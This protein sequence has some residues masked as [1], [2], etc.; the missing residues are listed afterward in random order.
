MN[1]INKWTH[2]WL[3]YDINNKS[4]KRHIDIINGCVIDLGC[5][6]SPYRDDI[7]KHATYYIG[8]DWINS[9]HNLRHV[10]IFANIS[11]YLPIK[12][13]SI[14]TIVSFQVLE[15]LQN[16]IFFLAECFRILR[17]GGRLLITTPFNW[18]VHE[19]PYDYYRF[20]RFG[21][22]YLLNLNSYQKISVEENT[23]FWQMW[24]LKFNY[25]TNRYAK[26]ILRY[27]FIPIWFIGQIIAPGLDN[28]DNHPE[29]TASY[30]VVATKP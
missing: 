11:S 16:P 18:H 9:F 14:D 29:E 19:A 4:L 6:T 20:T 26:G 27:F 22:E 30:T 7:L 15:H 24:I 8:V 10:S 23:G 28:I 12:E 13:N 17:P 3:A 25:H 2:N 1:K 21:L 5:G